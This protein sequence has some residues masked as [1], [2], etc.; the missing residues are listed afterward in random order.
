MSE[1]RCSECGSDDIYEFSDNATINCETCGEVFD[2]KDL[3]EQQN[4]TLQQQLDKAVE[5]LEDM[6]LWFDAGTVNQ[7]DAKSKT[8]Q[9]LK[10]IKG[11]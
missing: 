5:A 6:C 1:L 2:I 10:Q 3:L 4:A 7:E 11:E 8:T 9:T